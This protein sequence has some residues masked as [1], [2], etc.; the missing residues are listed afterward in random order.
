MLTLSG[1]CT[2]E[3]DP[4][5]STSHLTLADFR[6]YPGNMEISN[7][8]VFTPVLMLIAILKCVK[9]KSDSFSINLDRY[10]YS[11]FT[12][13][14]YNTK[15]WWHTCESL[16]SWFCTQECLY[17]FSHLIPRKLTHIFLCNAEATPSAH[18]VCFFFNTC[19]ASVCVTCMYR[20]RTIKNFYKGS[21][22]NSVT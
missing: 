18:L 9:F 3:V 12:F 4:K 1:G 11:M 17:V 22:S 6:R 8:V 13:I 19:K 21:H 16:I 20:D 2:K 15:C 14:L 5:S 7:F 10:H